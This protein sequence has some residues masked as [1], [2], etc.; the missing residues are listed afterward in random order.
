[1]SFSFSAEIF[2]GI[3]DQQVL[4][5]FCRLNMYSIP[6]NK[7]ELRNGRYFGRF[8]QTSY[9]LA[10][11]YLEFWRRH[12]VFTEQ[13]I[14]RMLEVEFTSELLI[15]GNAGMQDKKTSIDSF[16][17]K[18]EE[19][20]PDQEGNI[21]RFREVFS[22][23]SDTFDNEDLA[24]SAF[25]RPPLLYTL[26]CV[27]YHHVFGLPGIQRSSPRK[28]L[29]AD[30]RESLRDAVINLSEKIAESKDPEGQ[31]PRRYATFVAAS[32]R[33]TDKIAP[34]RIRFDALYDEAF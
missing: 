33:S 22:T 6:L 12:H 8:K 31:L 27:I 25:R 1:M 20:F 26:Y 24:N 28:R 15:A 9:S 2:K 34:R 3:S 10:L 7:Q 21:H 30:A 4:E 13:Y 32:L 14:A 11:N 16:Y 18:W 17:E 23:I 5:V 29:T 19:S